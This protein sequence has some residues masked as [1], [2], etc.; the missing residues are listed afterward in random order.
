ELLRRTQGSSALELTYDGLGNL[1]TAVST[2]AKATKTIDYT[3]DGFNRRVGKQV[4]GKFVRAWLYRDDL[5][6][7]A[8][9]TDTG[10]FSHFVYAGDAPGAPDFMLRAGVPFRFI[11]DHLGSVRLVVNAT[12]GVIAQRLDYDEFGNV[13]TDSAPGFQPFGFAGGLY[14][15]DTALVRF[16]SRDYDPRVGRWA[17]KD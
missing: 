6:P 11:K 15:A 7:V 10:V 1:L 4:G 13:T 17:S 9:I 5:R 2:S 14:D 12:T 8:E 3:V 16:G